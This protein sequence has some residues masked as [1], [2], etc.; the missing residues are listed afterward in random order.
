MGINTV[1]SGICFVSIKW[2]HHWIE[3]QK[4]NWKIIEM[5]RSSFVFSQTVRNQHW[6]IYWM[7]MFLRLGIDRV[8]SEKKKIDDEIWEKKTHQKHTFQNIVQES[9]NANHSNGCWS[10]KNFIRFQGNQHSIVPRGNISIFPRNKNP[11]HFLEIFNFNFITSINTQNKQIKN[12]IK[13][14]ESI[15]N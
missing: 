4:K 14:N 6:L 12:W 8:V 7:W 3:K 10:K 15:S 5:R 2:I 13:S 1:C 11:F 9:S